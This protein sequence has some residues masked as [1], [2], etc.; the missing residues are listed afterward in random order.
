MWGI[1][2]QAFKYSEDKTSTIGAE[3]SLHDFFAEKVAE[4]FQEDVDQDLQRKIVMQMSELWGGFV[5]GSV[6]K[7]SLKFFWLE[8]C[9]NGG[10]YSHSPACFQGFFILSE[11][12]N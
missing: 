6:K 9:I 12:P 2:A 1:I 5:G 10:K 4:E 11:R 7:Q 8:E 3:R